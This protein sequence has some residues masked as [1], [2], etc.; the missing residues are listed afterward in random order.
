M[1]NTLYPTVQALAE[2]TG[3]E[4][5]TNAAGNPMFTM[6]TTELI[7]FFL[8]AKEDAILNLLLDKVYK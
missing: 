8:D 1:T 5:Q 3:C 2:A 7:K 6:T 4:V